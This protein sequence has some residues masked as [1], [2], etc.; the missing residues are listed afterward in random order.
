MTKKERNFDRSKRKVCILWQ[1]K[2]ESSLFLHENLEPNFD[3]VQCTNVRV[4]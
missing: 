2:P 1:D 4:Y 3:M